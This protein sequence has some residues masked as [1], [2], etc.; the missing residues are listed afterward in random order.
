[1]SEVYL[2]G[3]ESREAAP[4]VSVVA[5]IHLK[6]PLRFNFFFFLL[7]CAAEMKQLFIQGLG[8]GEEEEEEEK[9]EGGGAR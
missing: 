6:P 9:R 8:G 1:M 3:R 7:N 2:K 4:N 5:K